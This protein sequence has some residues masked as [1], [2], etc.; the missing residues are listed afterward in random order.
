MAKRQSS[1]HN[2]FGK[3]KL[4]ESEHGEEKEGSEDVVAEFSGLDN[5]I[6]MISFKLD[7]HTLL[8]YYR[9]PLHFS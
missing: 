6:R 3:R 7:S 1:L 9:S 2:F 4:V 5:N 8:L